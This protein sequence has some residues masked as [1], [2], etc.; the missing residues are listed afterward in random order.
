MQPSG[1]RCRRFIYWVYSQ[2][3]WLRRHCG[4]EKRCR[5]PASSVLGCYRFFQSVTWRLK[6]LLLF[7]FD[8]LT[9]AW[10]LHH[11]I[12]SSSSLPECSRYVICSISLIIM[13]RRKSDI[14]INLLEEQNYHRPKIIKYL[15]TIV[16]P[17]RYI[18]TLKQLREIETS[19]S[20][21]N[22]VIKLQVL[23][24]VY[25]L[26][27]RT[28]HSISPS[29]FRIRDARKNINERFWKNQMRSTLLCIPCRFLSE[30]KS[31][32]L[33]RR[34]I[35]LSLKILFKAI[36][37]MELIGKASALY[38]RVLKRH[39]CTSVDISIS[40]GYQFRESFLL[41]SFQTHY[42]AVGSVFNIFK[43]EY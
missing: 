24:A 15:S 2:Y 8:G 39:S 16:L 42:V 23:F 41:R 6:L 36:S 37:C 29:H 1:W 19:V 35:S 5:S 30:I 28:R 27:A 33:L 26:F 9:Y 40:W 31:K 10:R 3:L 38:H 34:R 20:T 17:P 11:N 18:A 12:I 13:L 43:H 25:L 21:V 4:E 22:L 7:M 32:F 14:P